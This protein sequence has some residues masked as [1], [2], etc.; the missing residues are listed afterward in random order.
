MFSSLYLLKIMKSFHEICRYSKNN[1]I[2]SKIQSIKSIIIKC[3]IAI[4][5]LKMQ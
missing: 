2:T 1:L 4:N 3:Y 5:Q